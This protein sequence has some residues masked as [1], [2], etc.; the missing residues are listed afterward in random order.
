MQGDI[1]ESKK[2]NTNE[3]S[4]QLELGS[5]TFFIQV[6]SVIIPSGIC[7]CHGQ[8]PLDSFFPYFSLNTVGSDHTSYW[9]QMRSEA[10]SR[11]YL[12][13]ILFSEWELPNREESFPSF[14]LS[15]ALIKMDF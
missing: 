3:I 14:F 10:H 2:K 6:A 11:F 1:F 9:E 12:M 13:V 8:L 15:R 4:I 7:S 5:V